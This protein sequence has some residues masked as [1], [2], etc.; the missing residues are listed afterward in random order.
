MA[1]CPKCNKVMPWYKGVKLTYRTGVKCNYCGTKSFILRK[2]FYRRWSFWSGIIGA[3][4]AIFCHA[5]LQL[6]DLFSLI[7]GLAIGILFDCSV[8]WHY[9]T[10]EI[11]EN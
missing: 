11:K 7:L 5:F 2:V 10:L 8:G 1:K 9:S 4:V 6:S 3:A